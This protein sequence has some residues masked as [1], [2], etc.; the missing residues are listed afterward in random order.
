MIEICIAGQRRIAV[1]VC[2]YIRT[3]YSNILLYALPNKSD[4]G[5][6]SWQPSF[7][8]Y[9]KERNDIIQL[10]NIEDVYAKHNIIFLSLEYDKIIN[11]LKIHSDKLCFY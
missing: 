5:I 6:D 2:D 7:L 1:E 4:N 11:P 8:K 3:H 10:T 9:I